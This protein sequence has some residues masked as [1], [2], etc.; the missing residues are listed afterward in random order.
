M[1]QEP[2]NVNKPTSLP[3]VPEGP[4]PITEDSVPEF[5][6]IVEL[7]IVTLSI[8]EVPYPPV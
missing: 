6:V 1:K 7:T 4:D 8:C 5:A 3:G 2:E